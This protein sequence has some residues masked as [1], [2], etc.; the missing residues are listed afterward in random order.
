MIQLSRLHYLG[1]RGTGAGGHLLSFTPERRI[2]FTA[3]QHGLW[4]VPGGGAKPF[5]IASAPGPDALEP[6]TIEL[7]TVLHEA[8]RTKSALAALQPGDVVRFL[9][10]LGH[11]AP[12]RDTHTIVLLVQGIGATAARS[13]LR[14]P[15]SVH[16]TLVH[17]GAPHFR[18]ET[19]TLAD[20]A[21]YPADRHSFT[22]H[23][24]QV[25][26]AQPDAHFLLAGTRTFVTDTGRRLRQAGIPARRIRR[27]PFYGASEH[28]API[29]AGVS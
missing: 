13:L 16:R 28:Q 8:S 6:S 14:E 25:A 5:T 18:D 4:L 23:L 10:P 19:H 7:G 29:P 12:P 2:H 9:G 1:S 22:A 17:V 27:D 20:Q 24:D 26:T 15:S 11:L 21:Y 3:G